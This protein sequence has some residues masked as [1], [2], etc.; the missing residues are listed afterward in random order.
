MLKDDG[1]KT[2]VMSTMRL[3]GGGLY[4]DAKVM[5]VWHSGLVIWPG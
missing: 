5:S 2:V 3:A 4:H 1:P